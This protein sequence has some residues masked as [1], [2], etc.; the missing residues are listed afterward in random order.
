[1]LFEIIPSL[2]ALVESG[3]VF[4]LKSL[5]HNTK[6]DIHTDRKE[7]MGFNVAFSS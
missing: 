5:S 6:M 2:I 4:V 1:M 7:G 3:L